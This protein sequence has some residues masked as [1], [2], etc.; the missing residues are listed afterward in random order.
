[1]T[2]RELLSRLTRRH[3]DRD[4][5]DEI[6]THLELAESENLQ[7]GMDPAEARRRAAIKFG[8]VTSAK[9]GVWTQ[10]GLPG[11][12]SFLQDLKYSLRGMRKSPGFAAVTVLTLA[13]C[14]SLCSVIFC[15]LN[16]TF[17]RPAPGVAD[18]T[19]LVTLQSPVTYPHFEQY[20]GDKA[21]FI[22]PVP[23]TVDKA[24]IFGHLVSSEYFSL[25]GVEPLLGRFFDATLD[26]PGAA[27]TVVL[28]EVYWRTHLHSDPGV[29]GSSLRLNGIQATIVGV[30]P[31]DFIGILPMPHPAEIFVPVTADPRVAPE[32][33]DD[34]LH[35]TTQPV[36]RVLFRLPSGESLSAAEARLDAETR[37]FPDNLTHKDEKG[38]LVHVSSAAHL[39]PVTPALNAMI[40]MFY[41]MLVALILTLTCA[42][43][44]GLILARG[45][46]RAREIAVRLSIGAS[47][48]RL[49]RQLLTESLLLAVLG[50]AA[51]FLA[52]WGFFKI[53]PKLAAVADPVI[54][55]QFFPDFHL[56]LF[57]FLISTAAGVGFGLMPALAITR[58]DLAT[59]LKTSMRTGFGIHRRF[60]LRNL[61][62]VYQVAVAMILVLLMGFLTSESGMEPTAIP[63]SIPRLC[64]FSRSILALTD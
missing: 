32:L 1:M 22:G 20:R 30:A 29:V 19:G 27:P 52:I 51:G 7:R 9:E 4:F 16:G 39:A 15:T 41:T 28:S 62:V 47:R 40:V 48:L 26:L 8:S 43:L 50:G 24:R 49:I 38:R 23:F 61:F 13:I 60:G 36:F 5:E 55:R 42:N 17:L 31:K 46:A 6:A 34:A 64:M 37:G 3:L 59:A 12:G 33:A 11:F 57:A 18:P 58:P 45:R 53:L 63:A 44:A 54:Q 25:L 56:A 35:R 14:I 21:A 2:L 10:R